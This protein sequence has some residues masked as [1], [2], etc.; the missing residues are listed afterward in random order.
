MKIQIERNKSKHAECIIC[1]SRENVYQI[2]SYNNNFT[3]SFCKE[4]I[5]KIKEG[6]DNGI[7][8]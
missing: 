6:S 2:L 4:C 7:Q 1:L 3:L 8:K 5:D